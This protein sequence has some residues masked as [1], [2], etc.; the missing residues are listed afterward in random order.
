MAAQRLGA[1]FLDE[2]IHFD[3]ASSLYRLGVAFNQMAD[4]VNTL[5]ASRNS[6]SITSPMNCAR[7]WCG[8]A[9]AWP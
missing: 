7:R 8:Y 1:G 6:S 4:N 5:I 3:S 2:R 9:I